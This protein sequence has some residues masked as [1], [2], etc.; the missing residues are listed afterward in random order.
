MALGR[1]SAE[2][3][4]PRRLEVDAS[5][6]GTLSFKDPVNLQING[7][8]DGSLETKG[9]LWIGEK[10]QVQA[11]I[12]GEDITI[13]GS[14]NGPVTATRRLELLAT[15]R[16]IGKVSAP[17]LVVQ[18]GAVLH[19]LCEMGVPQDEPKAWMGVEELAAYLE[20]DAATIGEWA[21]AGRLP[22]QREGEQWRFERKRVEEWLAQEKI[23]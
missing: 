14:V 22:A 12:R 19:G 5:M 13:A 4:H 7:R 16:V 10:A 3:A 2:D 15:A 1:K 17:K 21:K 23:R 9:S 8:F 11:T 18:E 6:T 20:I